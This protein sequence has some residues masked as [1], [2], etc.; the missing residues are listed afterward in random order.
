MNRLQ[1][2]LIF[3]LALIFAV[4]GIAAAQIYWTRNIQHGFTVIGIDAEL[5][6]PS[7]DGYDQQIITTQLT[8]DEVMVVIIAENFHVVWLDVS[9][10][11]LAEGL[12]AEISGQYYDV[13]WH[14]IGMIEGT[15]TY[16]KHFD[17]IGESF[18]INEKTTVDKTQMM[19]TQI[20]YPSGDADSNHGYC[21]VVS[22]AWDTELVTIPGDYTIDILFQMGFV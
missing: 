4:S 20:D 11:S 14:C 2:A 15:H 3:V 22:F 18:Q 1:K 8:N 9:W 12:T 7:F 10:T 21:L 5:L 17:P 6:E 19:W 13:Y 16:E